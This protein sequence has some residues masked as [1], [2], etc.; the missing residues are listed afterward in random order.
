MHVLSMPP[1]FV[2]SQDQTLRLT[3]VRNLNPQPENRPETKATNQIN[4]TCH[5]RAS[6]SPP[7]SPKPGRNQAQRPGTE[8]PSQDARRTSYRHISQRRRPRIPSLYQQCQTAAGNARPGHRP[9]GARRGA[10]LYAPAAG[11]V[12]PFVTDL[13]RSPGRLPTARGTRAPGPA[14]TAPMAAIIL[15]RKDIQG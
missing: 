8:I 6:R 9:R 2:L 7:Q 5:K 11:S 13:F 14:E 12:K 10:G 15:I 3:Q 1:A 4:V